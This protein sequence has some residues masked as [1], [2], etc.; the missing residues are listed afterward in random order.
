MFYRRRQ[1][2]LSYEIDEEHR[3]VITTA[4]EA[5]S[6]EEAIQL[7]DRIRSDTRVNPE[8]FHLVDLTRIT[9]VDIDMT[10]MTELAARQSFATSRRAFVVGSNKLAYGM[11]RMF[12]AQ[13][14]GTGG[15]KMQVF[16]ERNEALLWLGIAPFN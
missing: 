7:Q 16:A 10:T 4:W 14:R 8:F 15:E 9:S 6:A 13:R 3:L 5:V 1:M 2:P 11:A 12:I